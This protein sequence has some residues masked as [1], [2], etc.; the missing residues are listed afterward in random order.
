[1]RSRK[2]RL[3]PVQSQRFAGIHATLLAVAEGLDDLVFSRH[4]GG[5]INPDIRS[6]NPPAVG[7]PGVM[8]HLG[9]M[10]HG[11]SRCAPGIDAGPAEV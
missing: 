2:A 10:N 5:H 4:N 1:M 3:P 9:A 6:S 8:R 11:F 7:V